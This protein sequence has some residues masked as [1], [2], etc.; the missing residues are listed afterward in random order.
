[1]R[2][3][4]YVRSLLGRSVARLVCLPVRPSASMRSFRFPFRDIIYFVKLNTRRKICSLL[5][6]PTPFP[7][8][9][10]HSHLPLNLCTSE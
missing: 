3:S 7:L 10:L 4:L 1:M 9:R 2:S 5:L 6:R 8:Q